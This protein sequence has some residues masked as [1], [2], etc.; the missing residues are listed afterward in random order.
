M[1]QLQTISQIKQL[2]PN[3]KG[4]D[5][6]FLY[7]SFGRNEANPNS[8]ID[9]QI[10]VN[11]NFNIEYLVQELHQEFSNEIQYIQEVAIKNKVV[12]Y[13]KTQPKIEFAICV[14]TSDIDKNYLGSEIKNV[15]ST[16]L[17]DPHYVRYY[18]EK[19]VRDNLNHRLAQLDTRQIEDLVSKFIYEF[20]NCSTMHKRSDGYQF[21]FFYNCALQAAVQLNHLSKGS[22]KFNFFPKRFIATTLTKEEQKNFYD[23]KGTLFLPEAN[24]QKRKLLNF[25]YSSI[26]QLVAPEK[27]DKIKEFCEWIYTRDFLWNFRDISNHNSKIKQG[28]IYRT[29]TM[30]LF[31]NES[32]FE[33]FIYEKKIKTVID[34]RADRE[35]AENNYTDTSLEKI[36]WVHTPFDP[37]NQSIDFQAN[38]HHG[39]DIEIAYRFFAIECKE[40]IRKAI[41]AIIAE[42][43]STAIHC[44][45]G[46]DRTGIFI[47]MLHLLVDAD[48]TTVYSD[49]LATEMDTK[50]EY[51]D[52]FLD[53][54]EKHGGIKN[55][56]LSCEL[57]PIQI[58]QL[59]QKLTHGND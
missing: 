33:N 58:E 29:A 22:T 50:K 51:L 15:E 17:Y 27:L 41:E 18:L 55:Y 14:N 37:W 59:N 24:Q 45:A 47:S 35:V 7:G 25:F 13:F 28:I 44:H 39:S 10:L 40:S 30:T 26:Q 12:V 42:P 16:V 53:I 46:K 23:L 43:H 49:Y 57:S 5:A 32:F 2:F 52:I 21:Y 38:Y 3:V 1:K 4:I 54:V 56:L 19:L 31:Q 34:L 8:D 6:A 11:Q 48:L 9:I 20:E 36:N